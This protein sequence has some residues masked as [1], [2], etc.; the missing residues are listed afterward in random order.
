MLDAAIL[1]L[2]LNGYHESRGESLLGQMAVAQVVLNRA[3]RDPA[4]VCGVVQER[5]QFSWT[6]KPPPVK[7][8]AAYR[9]ARDVA[10]VALHTNDF[11]GGA[12]FYHAISILPYWRAD[13]Q[14]T[15]QWGNHIFY[16]RK[17]K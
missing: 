6:L 16:K 4:K 15:G 8:E 14:V 5:A 11:T 1:C 12:T 17:G 7:D 9:H 10:T 13:L 2:A 3:G